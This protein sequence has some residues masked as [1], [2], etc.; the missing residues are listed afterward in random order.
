M[1]FQSSYSI[2]EFIDPHSTLSLYR[3]L[4]ESHR[5]KREGHFGKLAG[6][7]RIWNKSTVGLS[8]SEAASSSRKK[9]TSGKARTSH[10]DASRQKKLKGKKSR[11]PRSRSQLNSRHRSR[12]RSPPR[13]NF[14][15]RRL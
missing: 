9:L 3:P 7:L 14:S 11:S 1:G 5:P 6:K 15:T 2:P 10:R 13:S 12:S 8:A 4:R